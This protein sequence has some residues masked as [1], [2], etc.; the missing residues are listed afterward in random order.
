M[1]V[2]FKLNESAVFRSLSDFSAVGSRENEDT[3]SVLG[4]SF[5]GD[6]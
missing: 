2:S 3:V 1:V 4:E 6:L 5:L